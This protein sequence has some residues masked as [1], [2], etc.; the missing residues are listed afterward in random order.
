VTI[1]KDIVK[2]K[3]YNIWGGGGVVLFCFGFLL[4]GILTLCLLVS[5]ILPQE[6]TELIN[7]KRGKD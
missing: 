2:Q 6:I 4:L 3:G 1:P 7:L 5:H